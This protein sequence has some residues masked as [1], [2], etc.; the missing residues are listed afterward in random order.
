MS[1]LLVGC[2]ISVNRKDEHDHNVLLCILR[3]KQSLTTSY[4]W[5]GT[6]GRSYEVAYVVGRTLK[7]VCAEDGALAS[8]AGK[9]LK[10]IGVYM[11]G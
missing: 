3:K 5:S 9:K 2:L 4:P 1:S 11:L 6:S 8:S 10:Y 7:Y